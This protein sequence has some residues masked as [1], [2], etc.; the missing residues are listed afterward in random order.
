MHISKSPFS[1]VQLKVMLCTEVKSSWPSVMMNFT[2]TNGAG[3]AILRDSF[4]MPPLDASSE[5]IIESLYLP[6]DSAI[7]LNAFTVE[8][9]HPSITTLR[10]PVVWNLTSLITLA[11]AKVIVSSYGYMP[12]VTQNYLASVLRTLAGLNLSSNDVAQLTSI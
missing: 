1:V 10:A 5:D 2:I 7:D 4:C 8:V 11:F 3:C 6:L 12:V 9:W